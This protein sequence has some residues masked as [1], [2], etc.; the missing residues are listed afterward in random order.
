MP[1][2]NPN[3]KYM[4]AKNT[5]VHSNTHLVFG[6]VEPAKQRVYGAIPSTVKDPRYLKIKKAVSK[7]LKRPKNYRPSPMIM[8]NKEIKQRTAPDSPDKKTVFSRVN[9]QFVGNDRKYLNFKKKYGHYKSQRFVSV[10]SSDEESPKLMM[11]G[12]H[13]VK[14]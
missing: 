11:K 1:A 12:K 6:E 13:N 9:N 10:N 2:I 7:A 8:A 3:I 4:F 14:Y 5:A